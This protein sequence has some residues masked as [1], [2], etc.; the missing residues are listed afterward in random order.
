MAA[1]FTPQPLTADDGPLVWIDCEM[2][3]LDYKK[4]RILEIA[5]LITNGNLDIV[6]PSG[7][8]R[9][10]KTEKNILDNM[11]EWC[12]NQHGISGLTQKCL[13]SQH[14]YEDAYGS[15]VDYVKKWIPQKG[16]GVLAGNTV[17]MDRAFLAE[18]MPDLVDHLHYRIVD[19]S[20][21]KEL[22]KRWYPEASSRQREDRAESNHRLAYSS[23]QDELARLTSVD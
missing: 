3:G 6:D 1:S 11:H 8:E 12:I 18:G 23:V 19:V 16:I 9:V 2:T 21:V 14:T 13:D 10:I 7:F 20:S 22:C 17:H 4:D 5:V 15:V